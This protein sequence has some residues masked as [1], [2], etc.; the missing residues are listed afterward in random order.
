MHGWGNI[1][2]SYYKDNNLGEFDFKIF[3]TFYAF[4]E[5]LKVNKH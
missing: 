1:L 2:W 5:N 4:E 3:E